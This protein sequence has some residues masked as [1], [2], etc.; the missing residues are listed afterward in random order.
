MKIVDIFAKKLHAVAYLKKGSDAYAECEYDRLLDL[1]TD[2][3]YL[4]E[5]AKDNKVA[6]INKFVK[7]RLKDAE[8]IED[9]LDQLIEQDLPLDT[10]FHQLDNNEIGFKLLSLRKG[11]ASQQDGL[12][13]Y[14]IKIDNDCFLITGGAIKMSLKNK[15]H[16]DT[17]EEMRKI[18]EVK[19]YL[20][21]QGVIDR[22]SFYEFRKEREE[23]D[24]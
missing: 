22:E 9:L 20:Q 7:A 1:W 13:I 6:D 16:P 10:Y 14:A 24:K 23:D 3:E 8:Q 18:A 12:R 15:D 11:K 2:V 4:H 17:K 5:Y 19:A 21:D